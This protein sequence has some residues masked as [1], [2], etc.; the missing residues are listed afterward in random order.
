MKSIN[1][2]FDLF[3]FFF[4]FYD[5]GNTTT[6]NTLCKLRFWKFDHIYPNM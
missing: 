3:I 4:V 1:Q 6:W 2:D 5:K